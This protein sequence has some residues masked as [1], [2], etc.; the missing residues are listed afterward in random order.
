MQ[1]YCMVFKSLLLIF[2]LLAVVLTMDIACAM[3]STA[4]EKMICERL[5][6]K[7]WHFMQ[8]IIALG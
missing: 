6:S 1:F 7:Y 3:G 8:I 5:S 2:C 4:Q